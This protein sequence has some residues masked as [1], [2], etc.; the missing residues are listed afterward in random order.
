MGTTTK[1]LLI[2]GTVLVLLVGGRVMITVTHPQDDKTLI[3]K[4]LT[5]S[6]QASK[7]GRPGG[8]MD[9]LSDNIK[10][11][12]QNGS[13]YQRDIARFIK[14]SKPDIQVENLDPVVS[15]DEATIVSPVTL[16]VSM[17]G[18]SMSKRV[19]EV[20]LVFKKEED[21][22]F[23]IIPSTRWKLAEVRAAEGSFADM[24]Q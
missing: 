9:K 13:G 24:V 19:K 21:H 11:N 12:G 8:V 18:Q 17:L 16:T 10:Y 15:G 22:D 20:T 14:N 4:A 3:Q 6:I 2:L 5:E 1:T 7:E 23:L